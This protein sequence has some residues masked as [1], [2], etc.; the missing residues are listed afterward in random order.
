MNYAILLI[1]II[2]NAS[3]GILLK[4]SS[5][6]ESPKK[7]YIIGSG[8]LCAS[9]SAIL[10]TKALETL[11][12]GTATTISSGL[13]IFTCSIASVFIFNENYSLTKIMGGV[14]IFVGIFFLF[15]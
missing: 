11:S 5:F 1:S 9:I 10:Y 12:I 14:L 4:Y 15:K 2:F 8:F 13:V 7:F 6:L 3:S